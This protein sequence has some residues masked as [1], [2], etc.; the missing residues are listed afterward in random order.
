MI[1]TLKSIG[2]FLLLAT[3]HIA[4]GQTN[5]EKAHSKGLEAIKHM[6]NGKIDESILLLEEA[7]KL[8]P[9]RIDYPYE[10][11]YALYSRED[12]KGAIK[13][14]EKIKNHKD[15][16]DRLYQLLGNSYDFLGNSDKA[17]EVYDEGLKI[18][19]NSGMI[20]LEKGNVY[21]SKKEYKKALSFYEK[22]IQV[23]PKFP[24]NYY[25][26]ARIYCSS[27]EEIWGIIYGEIF[28]NL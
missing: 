15:V 7:Q 21:W 2:I 1:K 5:V 10:I 3:G 14:L 22:G 20:Y 13:I 26:A 28:M 19:P 24:S 11:A 16:L 18:F 25:R 6:D 4:L 27:S 12:Y 8:D 23:D 17:F 9:N